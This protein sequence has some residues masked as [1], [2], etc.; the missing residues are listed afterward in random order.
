MNALHTTL[1]LAALVAGF[2]A[3]AVHAAT[4]VGT[5]IDH[6]GRGAVEIAECG[7][8][9]CGHVVWL[10]DAKNAKACRDQIIGNVKLVGSN[11][12][13][14]GWIVDPDDNARYSV[15]LKPVGQDKLRVTGYMGSKLFSETMMWKRAPADLK[16]C[17]GK[18][19][20]IPVAAPVAPATV[21]PAPV[22]PS[23]VTAPAPVL[24]E[25][26]A[27]VIAPAAPSA[28]VAPVIEASPST[29]VPTETSNRV[30]AAPAPTVDAPP[31]PERRAQRQSKRKTASRDC[32]LDLP[33]ITV[34]IC[35]F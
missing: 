32:K 18:D 31:Q 12:W 23:A 34:D 3:T 8:G 21:P 15:E 13:D 24:R 11:T 28:S 16:R 6:T 27:P 20:T 25:A 9:L 19:T 17:D 4:P 30:A 14:R 22:E 35:S 1:R 7:G 2:A 29:V 33:Y 26:S 5:W 10:K